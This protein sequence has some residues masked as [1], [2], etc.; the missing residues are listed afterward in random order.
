MSFQAGPEAAG[1]G[2]GGW[3]LGVGGWGLGSE[4]RSHL[5]SLQPWF[6]SQHHVPQ[7]PGSPA[8]PKRGPVGGRNGLAEDP[9]SQ[10]VV[11]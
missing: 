7:V 10:Q 5:L 11:G 4:R 1:L 8:L 2:A 9:V 3:E 6:S